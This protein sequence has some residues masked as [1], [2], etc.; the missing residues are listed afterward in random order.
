M[1]K[2]MIVDDAP[3]MRS[4]LREIVEESGHEVAV[5]AATGEEAVRLYRE[6]LPDLVTM[7][8]TMPEMNG[9]HALRNIL[10]FNPQAKI[11]MCSAM[12]QQKLMVEAISAGAKEFIMKPFQKNMVKEAIHHVLNKY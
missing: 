1:A 6:Y 8:I 4:M 9:I 10:R 5:E 12:G 7:D 11:I 3:F 2:I